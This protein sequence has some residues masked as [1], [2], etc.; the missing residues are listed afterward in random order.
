MTTLIIFLVGVEAASTSSRIS[1]KVIA[2]LIHYFLLASFCWMAAQGINLYRSLVRVLK[3]KI[4]DF[5]YF[6]RSIVVCFGKF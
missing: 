3:K 4:S 5:Q 1:C 6:L 2:G